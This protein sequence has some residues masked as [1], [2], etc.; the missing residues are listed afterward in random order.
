MLAT[1]SVSASAEV[2]LAFYKNIQ[3]GPSH[4]SEDF[5]IYK[6]T[7]NSYYAECTYITSGTLTITGTNNTPNKYLEF[8]SEKRINFL[9]T[10]YE[11]TLTFTA[12][13]SVSSST[14]YANANV[15]VGA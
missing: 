14:S 11:D 12:N 7:G 5:W 10:T 3:G 2:S 8:S 1:M 4:F 13:Y 6:N 9:S 15:T